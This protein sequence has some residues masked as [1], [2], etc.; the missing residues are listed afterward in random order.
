MRYRFCAIFLLVLTL[1]ACEFPA[2]GESTPNATAVTRTTAVPPASKPETPT[3]LPS[4]TTPSATATA[5]AVPPP[6]PTYNPALPDW[7]VLVYMT[8]D[9]NLEQ[10]ALIDI[11]E[12]ERAAAS[13]QVNILAQ[14]DSA[15]DG[16]R[17]LLIRPDDDADN[18]GSKIAAELGELNMGDPQTLADFIIWGAANYPA[19][20]YALIIWDHGAGWQ[21]IS[22]DEE[23]V[24]LATDF[25]SLPDLDGALAQALTQSGLD[26]LDVVGFD[27]CLMGQLD[28]FQTVAPYSDYAV[29]SEAL[30]PGQ[31]WQYATLLNHLAANPD[32]DGAQL[33]QQMTADYVDFYTRAEPDDFVTMSAVDLAQM[34]AVT[35]AVQQLAQALQNDPAQAA[36]AVGDARYGAEAYARPFG[37]AFDEYAAI[38]LSHF[39]AILAQRSP[40]EAVRAA[41]NAVV[42][43]VAA[44]V[45]ANERGSGFRYSGGI[46]HYFPRQAQFYN[47][48]YAQTTTNLAW[49]DFLAAYYEA[50][51]DSLSPPE[52]YLTNAR[53]EAAGA[54]NP[55][56]LD[57]QIVGRSVETVSL[58]GGRYEADGRRRLLELDTLIPE[59]SILPDG[60]RLSE[61]RDGVH[62]DFFIWDTLT[63]YLF[64]DADNGDFVVMTAVTDAANQGENG[65]LYAVSGVF[66]SAT[67][68]EASLVFDYASGQLA[69]VWGIT[70]GAAA[71]ITPRPGDLF[72]IDSLYLDENDQLVREP[73]PTL[74]F[75][76]TSQLYFDWRP[77]PDGDYFLGL[78][79][80]NSAGKTAVAFTDLPVENNHLLPNY[81]AYLDPYLGFQFLYPDAWYTPIYTDTLLYTSSRDAATDVQI[82]LYPNLEPDV[83]TAAL[84]EQTLNQFGPVDVLF[85][86]T[87]VIAGT[88]G[89]RISYG[90]TKSSGAHT[91]V[92]LAFVRDGVGYVVDVDGVSEDE[93]ATLTA[94]DIIA[95]SWQFVSAGAGLPPGRWAQIDAAA[96]S[97]AQPADFV[98]QEVNNW[99]RFS[100]GRYAFVALRAQSIN[101]PVPDVL[102]ALIRDAGEGMQAFAAD[103]PFS[104]LLGGA[105]WERANFSYAL[106]DGSAIWGFIMVKEENGQ[107]VVAWAEAP[108]D[109]YN[110]LEQTAFLVMI[111]DLDLKN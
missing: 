101:R 39:A 50:G 110:E 97:V 18:I 51:Q 71:E 86:D 4:P 68:I 6:T 28:V 36:G 74:V 78:S 10:A 56:Y 64:D 23:A 85:T 44:A 108:S 15:G 45:I 92:F 2:I 73:G 8:A 82:T 25:L 94:V 95:S 70:N 60:S 3:A 49:N 100:N 1:T 91:G 22:F 96:F 65:R 42:D 87:A 12:M 98:Y 111:A 84:T 69:R 83:D 43:G 72:R 30:T 55:A 102:A 89:Q 52:I 61:W 35:T 67:E 47:T 37:A 109:V 81:S 20:R 13:K 38:D 57:F 16:A 48:A 9:N 90:Y 58:L 59:P 53:N 99:Q 5:T 11:N 88:Q 26:K 62:E 46:A 29:A 7:T 31:G 33:A 66:I 105:I 34:G 19:N 54:Q 40:D 93:A 75:D 107:E 63:T 106:E 76:E 103:A 27:A 32:M 21:G 77:L 79:A 17:R 104:T 24:E 41:A 80:E 14:I